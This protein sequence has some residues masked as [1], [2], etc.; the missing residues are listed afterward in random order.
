MK[1]IYFVCMFLYL[2]TTLLLSQS[3]PVPLADQTAGVTSPIGSSQADPKAQARILDQY[4]KLPLSFEANRGQV[5]EHVKFL[6]HTGGYTLFLTGDEAVLEL[7]GR[8]TS[9]NKAKMD[10]A[11][12]SLQSGMGATNP[13]GVLRVKLRN[14]NP[15]AKVTG[16]DEL[17]GT[18]N[19]FI[20]SD[21][22]N[23]RKNVPNY[24]K[25]KYEGIYSGIDLVY[26]G[27]ERQ[28]EYDFIVSPGA[29]A[30]R[31]SLR[32]RGAQRIRRDERGDLV[33]DIG[34]GEILW[35]KPVAYQQENGTRHEIAAHY[36]IENKNRVGF[37][38]AKYDASRPLYIDP[39]VYSTY[40]GG[41]YGNYGNGIT[42]DSRGN[43]YVTGYTNSQS[44]PTT[45]G[46]FQTYC[47]PKTGPCLVAYAFVTEFNPSGG[48]VYST[49]LGAS[50]RLSAGDAEGNGIAVDAQGEAYVTGTAGDGFPVTPGAFQATC[51]GA[52]VTEINPT[53]SALVY[54]T[55]LG[56]GSGYGIAVDSSGN[57]YVTGTT[58]G[59]FPVTPGAFQTTLGGA[60]NAFV[61]KLNPTGSALVYSTY[62]GGTGPDASNAIAVDSSGNAY[63]TGYTTS[64]NFPVTSG[65]FQTACDVDDNGCG[66][67]FIST[68][69]SAGS[70]LVYST[71]LGGSSGYD[72]GYGIAVDSASNAYITGLTASTDFPVTLGALQTNY[73]GA[74]DAFV[75]KINSAGSALVYSTYLGGSGQDNGYGI[76]VD[77]VGNAYV[78]G[79]TGSANFP[80][81][82]SA[83][84]TTCCGAFVTEINAAG[85]ALVYSTYLDNGS[86]S[87]IAVDSAANIYLTGSTTSDDF[88]V[89]PNALQTTCDPWCNSNYPYAFVSEFS[90]GPFVTLSSASLS[91]GNQNVGTTSPQQSTT[92]TNSGNAALNINTIV[93]NGDFSET[94]TCPVGSSLASGSN[95]TIEVTFTPTAEGT[96]NGAVT[97]TDN[98]PGNPQAV[99]LTG[100]GVSALVTLSP[101]SLNFS[102]QTV[103]T[104]S[105]QQVLT[106]SNTGN[107]TLII[108]AI[109][110]SG[111]SSGDFVQ[112]NN[113]GASVPAGGNCNISVTF[114]PTAIGTRT[115]AV[116]ITDNALG[117]P[118]TVSLTGIGTPPTRIHPPAKSQPETPGIAPKPFKIFVQSIQVILPLLSLQL[119]VSH[120]NTAVCCGWN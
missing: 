67:A 15:A 44:F 30:H 92:L 114:T 28:L 106:L 34:D 1:L 42:V 105:L 108:T 86:A 14:A 60:Q 97:I 41:P 53:G 61:S 63:V 102:N 85:S 29:D 118:Q 98:A 39:L 3:N 7:S 55:Y 32:L 26:Y 6:S 22:K 79:Q 51:C 76:A 90:P 115:A 99:S 120:N 54:S 113:C 74:W 52:F 58:G 46:A 25:V 64:N 104:T 68:I 35:R 13:A 11:A 82:P 111:P 23:W 12:H 110:V 17:A 93:A 5:N 91:F 78:T 56:A 72:G 101:T 16:V 112:T 89:T 59:G 73:G 27:N 109:G 107:G 65:A 21:P 100:V 47:L 62:L 24:K 43:F 45:P 18:S 119:Y 36:V 31:I 2:T 83:F 117:S 20:G 75:S 57:A 37:E 80:V 66:N 70:G 103:G 77:T 48:L 94:N 71:Y 96:R 8:K 49:Y 84:Q 116:S 87:S 88:P 10:G 81:T 4:G 38:V 9:T 69:N 50:E 33:L 19:Y 95:C 40:L